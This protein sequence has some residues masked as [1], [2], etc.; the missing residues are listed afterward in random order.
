VRIV[1]SQRAPGVPPERAVEWW[2]DFQE[3]PHDHAFV[4]GQRRTILAREGGR[5]T[6][7]DDVRPLGV[8]VF[9]ERT[10]AWREGNAVRFEGTNTVSR[11]RGSYSFEDD[12]EGG[13]VVTLDADVDLK[14]VLKAGVPIGKPAARALLRADLRH[15]V[16][17]MTAEAGSGR[18]GERA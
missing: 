13:S 14:G 8:L 10:T 15:H 11:F 18:G 17:E 5:V 1:L 3:G 12:G 6:M 4:R 2:C 16:E 9:R 7:R